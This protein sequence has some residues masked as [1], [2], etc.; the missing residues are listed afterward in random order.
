MKTSAQKTSCSG[1]R[2]V[3][4]NGHLLVGCIHALND[5][6]HLLRSSLPNIGFHLTAAPGARWAAGGSLAQ[7]QV[8]PRPLDGIFL[9]HL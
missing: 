8:N 5:D 9:G 4:V 6:L 1:N 7:P 2:P 3:R